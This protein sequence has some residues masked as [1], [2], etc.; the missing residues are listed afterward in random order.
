V[1]LSGLD[2]QPERPWDV[3]ELE[4]CDPGAVNELDAAVLLEEMWRCA[5]PLPE[6]DETV[7]AELLAPY[8]RT[9]PG[10]SAAVGPQISADALAD[11]VALLPPRL[12]LG[13]VAASR[14]A[15]LLAIVG[16]T[17][18]ELDAAPS[19]KPVCHRELWL[20]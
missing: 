1:L 15:D 19:P 3:G 18:G 7:T 6:E 14:P 9:F 11:A 20:D 17:A 5:V 2:R 16:W 4:P 10:L 8:S 13:L 12:R